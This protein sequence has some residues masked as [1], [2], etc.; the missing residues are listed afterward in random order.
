VNAPVALPT[1]VFPVVNDFHASS[2]NTTPGGEV[3][4]YWSVSNAESIYID[5]GV[6][7]VSATGAQK[8]YPTTTTTYML[9]AT[10]MGNST[11]Q[12]VTITVR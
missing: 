6:G 2:T 9:N 8:V 11:L 3:K 7:S 4:L 12:T 1:P 10:N 5:H